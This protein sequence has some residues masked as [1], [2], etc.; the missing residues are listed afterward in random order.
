MSNYG[1]PPS[2]IIPD[3]NPKTILTIQRTGNDPLDYVAVTY[4]VIHGLDA[5]VQ[6]T[7]RS[8]GDRAIPEQGMRFLWLNTAILAKSHLPG[9]LDL[10]YGVMAT[11][12]RGI[13]EIVS[14][15]G[16][17]ALD[18]EVFTGTDDEA[19]HRGRLTLYRTAVSKETE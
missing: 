2:Y 9:T 16:A 8:H 12:L 5:L 11:L 4:M 10:T 13:W 3:S 14:L 18:M 19:H 6:E 15:W 7:I 1:Y 17:N